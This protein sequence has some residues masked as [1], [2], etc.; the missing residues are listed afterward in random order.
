[1]TFM[2][3]LFD[4]PYYRYLYLTYTQGD[5]VRVKLSDRKLEEFSGLSGHV[6]SFAL[7]HTTGEILYY[8]NH[9]ERYVNSNVCCI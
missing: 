8:N 5:M 7:S 9:G 3:I 4:V 2:K 1:M 6:S